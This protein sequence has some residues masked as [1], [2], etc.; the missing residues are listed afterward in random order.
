[1][2]HRGMRQENYFKE[3]VLKEGGGNGVEAIE[4]HDCGNNFVF[5]DWSPNLGQAIWPGLTATIKTMFLHIRKIVEVRMLSF[6]ERLQLPPGRT[7]NC[8]RS[9]PAP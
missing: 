3:A 9:S 7:E 8:R 4:A 2:D 1:M 6:H 5:I